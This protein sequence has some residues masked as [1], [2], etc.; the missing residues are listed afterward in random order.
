MQN[1]FATCITLIYIR[2]A[3]NE[4]GP[5]SIHYVFTILIKVMIPIRDHF[6]CQL[7]KPKNHFSNLFYFEDCS[8]HVHL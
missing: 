2:N 5:I 4:L 7:N 8:K 6:N 1:I 3:D